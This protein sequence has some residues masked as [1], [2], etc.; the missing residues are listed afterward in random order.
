MKYILL[1][2][3]LC[4]CVLAGYG[5]AALRGTVT[6]PS[7]QP[8]P[9][10]N[11][12]IAALQRGAATD[13]YGQYRISNLT[14]G[15]YI[16]DISAVGYVAQSLP[17]TI[18]GEEQTELN[19]VLQPGD[20]LLRDVV[21]R[22][23]LEQQIH[24]L[25]QVDMKL[26]PTNTAQDILRMIPGLF[27]AQHAG[28]G[29]A[30]QIF[31]RGF[32]IDHGTDINLE[33]DGMPVNMVSHAHGQ[34]YSD[35]HFL[36]P[37]LV[38]NVD[39]NK[40]PY[41][42]DKGNFAT[43]GYAAFHTRN[44]LD[45][46]MVKLEGGAFGTLRQV[47]AFNL[48]NRQAGARRD[49]AYIA[50]EYFRTNGFFDSPQHFSRFNAQAKYTGHLAQDVVLSVLLSTFTSRWDASGQ[51]PDRA[52]NSGLISRFGSLDNT[53]GGQTSRTNMS[54]RV[55]KTLGDGSTIDNQVYV[56][57]Y[58]FNLISNF[59]FY[60]HDPVN[61]DQ[62]TQRE[63]R[64]LYGYKGTWLNTVERGALTYQTEG[65]IGFRY[66]NVGDSRLL[67]TQAR[68]TVL[69]DI[70][71]GAIEETNLYAYAGER[72]T[73]RDKFT[74]QAGLRYD[75][76]T[77]NYANAL[78]G[79]YEPQSVDKG[80]VSPKLQITYMP[81]ASV[82]LFIK[83][84]TGF[85]SN[86]T[87]VVVAQQGRT[88]LPRAT[89]VDVGATL[90]VGQKLLLT[91]V[92]W[93]LDLQ[94]EFVYVGDEGVVE[95]GGKTRRQG[96]DLSARY[97]LAR[98]WYADVDFNVTR[99]R[100]RFAE[101]G[102]AYIPLAPTLTS[103]GGITY[104]LNSGISGSLRYRYLGDRPANE[105]NSVVANGYFLADAVV[106]YTRARFEW[107]VSAENIFNSAWKEAQFDTESQ[108]KDEAA[109]VSEIHFTP[110]TPLYIKTGI[111]FFF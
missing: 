79:V 11:L 103:I 1:H 70:T 9:D 75:Y 71:R 40:G 67:H 88:I 68:Y 34:G 109:P 72:I 19:I 52:V 20:L 91:P 32:D 43:A 65:G 35:L 77:F 6:D 107:Y 86:D 5:H 83:S 24:T 15:Q 47:N 18:S 101:D 95:P 49:Q 81:S 7:G 12:Y 96:F 74:V 78:T 55:T 33:V 61:G 26:R 92:F 94:Q 53:E 51:V 42:I 30:E 38:Q 90:K 39:F 98:G 99:P 58:D 104:S 106:R 59:T 45:Q 93:M 105:D 41:D 21:I 80:I 108:L 76:L 111:S 87:R 44:I 22:H 56:S 27:I 54:V 48:V 10:V 50:T 89:G 64:N 25:S 28:G 102:A 17:V 85:H 82:N 97:Q 23:P 2:C 63:G 69:N 100:N 110:G 3:I 84:G 46:N 36:I 57:R 73:Y 4:G 62:I 16:V 66:D 31:L 29:K 13:A 37:E 8:L 60:L 14:P